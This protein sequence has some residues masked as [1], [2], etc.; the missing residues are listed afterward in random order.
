M[1]AITIS[2]ALMRLLMTCQCHDCNCNDDGRKDGDD[3]DDEE[4]GDDED[5]A[6]VA[7]RERV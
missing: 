4:T 6:V 1:E 7:E 2:M 5:V 3:V